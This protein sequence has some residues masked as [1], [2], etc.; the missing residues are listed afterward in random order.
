MRDSRPSDGDFTEGGLESEGS[1]PSAADAAAAFAVA[2]LEDQ[3]LVGLLDEGLEEPALDFQAGLMDERLDLVGEMLV[4][5]W[6]G[7]G[8]VQL[9]LE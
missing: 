3:F 9:E 1:R 5:L 8:H 4:L 6:Q 7:Q 2:S